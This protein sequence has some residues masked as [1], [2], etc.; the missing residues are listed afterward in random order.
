ML[1]TEHP[2]PKKCVRVVQK[3]RTCRTLRLNRRLKQLIPSFQALHSA[4]SKPTGMLL[5]TRATPGMLQHA[6]Q[7]AIVRQKHMRVPLPY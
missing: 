1:G 7:G 2:P 4:A 6:V 3:N 5:H